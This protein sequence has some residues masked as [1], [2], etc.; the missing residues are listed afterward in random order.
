MISVLHITPSGPEA[1][2]D[3]DSRQDANILLAHAVP[4]T[5]STLASEPSAPSLPRP[6]IVEL[7]VL[8]AAIPVCRICSHPPL[9]ALLCILM[10]LSCAN[11][12][13]C[14]DACIVETH[15]K[16]SSV[17]G[18]CVAHRYMLRPPLNITSTQLYDANCADMWESLVVLETVWFIHHPA[19]ELWLLSA[20]SVSG[21]LAGPYL[22]C[23]I[24]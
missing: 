20:S 2:Y 5:A 4:I 14:E 12:S 10:H 1:R 8:S 21:P 17:R 15:L 19:P 16:S 7:D 6:T 13:M 22:E 3:R 9:P 23:S 24:Q 18:S 11:A